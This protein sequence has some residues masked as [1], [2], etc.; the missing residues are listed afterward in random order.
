MLEQLQAE[1]RRFATDEI[2]HF[3][4]LLRRYALAHSH[5]KRLTKISVRISKFHSKRD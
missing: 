5:G 3:G 2:W 4:R 1:V